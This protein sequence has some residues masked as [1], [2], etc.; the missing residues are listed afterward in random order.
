VHS[1][2]DLV[3]FHD[4]SLDVLETEHFGRRAVAVLPDRFHVLFGPIHTV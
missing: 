1:D 3:V 2:E 4:W